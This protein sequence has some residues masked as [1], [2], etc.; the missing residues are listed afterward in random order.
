MP[1]TNLNL[2]QANLVSLNTLSSNNIYF[3]GVDYYTATSINGVEYLNKLILKQNVPFYNFVYSTGST[4]SISNVNTL[5]YLIVNTN[6]DTFSA[7]F[8]SFTLGLSNIYVSNDFNSC[9]LRVNLGPGLSCNKTNIF[10]TTD[11]VLSSNTNQF[12][13][14]SYYN[15]GSLILGFSL[16]GVPQPLVTPPIPIFPTPTPTASITP[17][18]TPTISFTPTQPPTNTQTPTPSLSG[19]PITPTPTSTVTI[20]PT[21]TPTITITPTISITP[22]RTQTPTVTPT[23][24]ITP[25]RTQTP[26]VTPT[27]AGGGGITV[28]TTTNVIVTFGDTSS[29]NYARD[30]YPTYTSYFVS[31]P[32]VNISFQRLTFNIDVANTWALVQYSSGEGGGLDIEATNTSANSAIIP[33]TGWVYTIGS[34]PAITITAA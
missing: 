23:V 5:N 11:A 9:Q 26:T 33:T 2:S 30:G 8:G 16:S 4:L 28:A 10:V 12:Y 34:G 1:I 27:A 32:T 20:T 29:I 21:V 6:V 25:T 7:N 13:T 15:T 24:T 19:T 18:L 3:D 22:T 17:T 14:F 31:N